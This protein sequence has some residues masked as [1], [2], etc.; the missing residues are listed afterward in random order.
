VKTL[1]SVL[2][3]V[4]RPAGAA[5]HAYTSIPDASGIALRQTEPQRETEEV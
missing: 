4:A 5:A 1:V 3:A 2:A